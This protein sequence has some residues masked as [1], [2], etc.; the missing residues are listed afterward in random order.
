MLDCRLSTVSATICVFAIVGSNAIAGGS[1]LVGYGHDAQW[2]P[3]EKFLS[4]IRS[5]TLFAV[6][7]SEQTEAQVLFCGPVVQSEWIDDSIMVIRERTTHNVGLHRICE[8]RI[9]LVTLGGSA[10]TIAEDRFD[11]ASGKA[12]YST[13]RRQ[14]GGNVTVVDESS[15]QVLEVEA[16]GLVN[17]AGAGKDPLRSP[18]ITTRPWPWGRVVLCEVDEQNCRSVTR[19]ENQYLLPK[20]APTAD[21][22]TCASSRGDL[23]VFDTLGNELANLGLASFESW[24]NDGSQ[25]TFCRIVESEFGIDSSEVYVCNFDGSGPIQVTFTPEFVEVSPAF[26]P[27]GRYVLYHV[28]GRNEIR[29][30]E[31]R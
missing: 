24:A 30:L 25:L 22:F 20:L 10:R 21:R 6:D 15:E 17:I 9:V 27:S 12:R 26:S 31:L 13:L 14:A 2:S 11:I 3:G 19:G 4:L 29:I 5:D 1:I 8:E 7:L 23:L 28:V 18:L 16:H